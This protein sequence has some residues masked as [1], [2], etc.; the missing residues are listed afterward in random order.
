LKN[1]D[2]YNTSLPLNY[3]PI[4]TYT[5][6]LREGS[7]YWLCILNKAVLAL[8]GGSDSFKIHLTKSGLGS[9]TGIEQIL[10]QPSTRA[11]VWLIPWGIDFCEEKTTCK[12]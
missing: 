12:C 7:K 6:L 1:T 8:E 9:S 5:I 4:G 10:S 3:E 11:M 2:I